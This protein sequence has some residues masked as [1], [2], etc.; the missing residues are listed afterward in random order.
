MPSGAR[1]AT[2][3]CSLL[4][5]YGT[6]SIATGASAPPATDTSASAKPPHTKPKTSDD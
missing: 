6:A 1:T 2:F 5:P 4:E 3:P